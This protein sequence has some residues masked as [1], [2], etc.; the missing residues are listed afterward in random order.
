MPILSQKLK[1]PGW[2]TPQAT[3]PGHQ[4]PGGTSHPRG[5]QESDWLPVCLPSCPKCQHCGTQRHTGS[6]LSHIDG[7]G[8]LIPPILLITRGFPHW[9]TICFLQLLL[10]PALEHSPRP[11]RQLPFPD[12]MDGM[13]LGRTTSKATTEGPPSSRQQEVSP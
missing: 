7:A 10:W 9:A 11:K 5:R 13:P 12:P 2:V 4:I 1:L 3:C 6:L 8:T